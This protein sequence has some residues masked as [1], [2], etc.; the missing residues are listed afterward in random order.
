MVPVFKN[1]GE[2]S[3]GKKYRPNGLLF[4]ISSMVLGLLSQLQ[5]L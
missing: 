3:T 5:I 1:A 2:K 4:Q